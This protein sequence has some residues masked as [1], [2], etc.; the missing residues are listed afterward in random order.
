M[1]RIVAIILLTFGVVQTVYG[2]TFEVV[3]ISE[4]FR[5]AVLYDW[6]MEKEWV[7]RKGVEIRG[8]RVWEITEGVVTVV[9]PVEGGAIAAQIPMRVEP[10]LMIRKR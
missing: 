8:W 9:M 4:D 1:C 10:E 7:V 5:E 3:A 2:Q 6:E